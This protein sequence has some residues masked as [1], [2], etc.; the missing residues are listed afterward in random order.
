MDVNN[1]LKVESEINELGVIKKPYISITWMKML[2]FKQ[3]MIYATCVAVIFSAF[4]S[5]EG[6]TFHTWMM[7]VFA[8]FL[9][10]LT[11]GVSAKEGQVL[12]VYDKDDKMWPM[13]IKNGGVFMPFFTNLE[14]R[15]HDYQ[16][17]HENTLEKFFT[18]QDGTEC[19]AKLHVKFDV[20]DDFAFI[21]TGFQDGVYD[22]LLRAIISYAKDLEVTDM[23]D[24]FAGGKEVVSVFE[25]I[26]G[27]K[28][29]KIE[30]SVHKRSL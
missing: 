7:T 13:H 6:F 24:L 11:R 2:M 17:T 12:S 9:I 20:V 10:F 3:I 8:F 5:D 25:D 28:I 19:V 21:N 27:V 22:F 16:K 15:L 14:V 1:S 18:A 23:E 29:R 30:T 26:Y 4:S